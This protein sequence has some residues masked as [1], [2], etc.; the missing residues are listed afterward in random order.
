MARAAR[1]AGGSG[2]G[3]AEFYDAR[4]GARRA[5][6]AA[7]RDLIDCAFGPLN[8]P[9]VK[10]G[11]ARASGEER[12]RRRDK[13]QLAVPSAGR[14]RARLAFAIRSPPMA[15]PA[16]GAPAAAAPSGGTRVLST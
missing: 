12:R 2:E 8:A 16:A 11:E 5:A 10:T 7:P 1:A 4:A 14:A 13:G 3:G 15:P 9:H 6:R